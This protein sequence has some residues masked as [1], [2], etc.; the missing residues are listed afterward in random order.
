MKKRKQA[1]RVTGRSMILLPKKTLTEV[2]FACRYFRR[3]HITLLFLFVLFLS[4]LYSIP[5]IKS[6]HCK[7]NTETLSPKPNL[8]DEKEKSHLMF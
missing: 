7:K 6:Y 3:C 1:M 5:K 8:V 4:L 2:C